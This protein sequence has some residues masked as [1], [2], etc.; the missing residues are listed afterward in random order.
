MQDTT[1]VWRALA[2]GC[3]PVT[4]FRATELPFARYLG[5]DYRRFMV[6]IQP[7]D[8]EETPRRLARILQEPK[9]LRSLQQGVLEYQGRFLWDS[10]G[11]LSSLDAELAFRAANLDLPTSVYS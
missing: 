6:N 5:L 11:V 7:D 2:H 10:A 4:F 8:Y 3:I 1:R 9:V